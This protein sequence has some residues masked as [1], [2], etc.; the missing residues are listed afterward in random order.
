MK[1][2]TSFATR[3]SIQ[4][5]TATLASTTISR[6]AARHRGRPGHAFEWAQPI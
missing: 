2:R 6:V 5:L 1:L 3:E 4:I